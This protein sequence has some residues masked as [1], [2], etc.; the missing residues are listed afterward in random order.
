MLSIADEYPITK[1]KVAW[2]DLRF[3]RKSSSEVYDELD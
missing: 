2:Y 1:M 3:C